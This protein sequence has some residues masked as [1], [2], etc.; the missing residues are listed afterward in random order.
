[1][2]A[3]CRTGAGT[4]ELRDI[5]R[6]NA[7]PGHVVIK[8][9]ACGIN[10]GDKA[11]I[12]GLFPEV[13]VSQH[14]VCGGSA[15]GTVIAAGEGVPPDLLGRKVTVYRSLKAS[16]D[17]VGTWSEFNRMHYLTCAPLPDEIDEAEYAASLVSVVT[18]YLFL[19]RI[20][21]DGHKAVVCTA[22]TSATGRALLG[23]CLARNVPIISIVPS[24]MG[25]QTLARL[26]AQHILIRNSPDFD[27][28][29]ARI[30]AQIGA[31][32]VFDGVGGLFVGRVAKALPP[33]S[34]IFCYGFL[35]GPENLDFP[36]SLLLIKDLTI[37][38][39]S[40]LRP[41]VR[42]DTTLQR[43]IAGVQQIIVMP[44]F[45]D[46]RGEV[47]AF[48]RAAAALAWQGR[49]KAVLRP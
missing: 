29:L 3:I 34:T 46:Q 20:L 31:T 42:D 36:S 11:L 14:D 32:A 4:V 19:E 10:P 18:A 37:T 23:V 22:G 16:Q 43:L 30:A 6:P 12:A 26:D 17:C 24:E 9:T 48:D 41:L 2:R 27:A 28:A 38:S 7:T 1:M 33:G 45:R 35:A 49:G 40:V 15:S 44:H 25:R 8:T 39:F 13:P 21:A 47:F 5:P